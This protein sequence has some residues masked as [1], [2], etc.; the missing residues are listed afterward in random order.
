MTA[1]SSLVHDRKQ[2][3]AMK[4]LAISVFCAGCALVPAACGGSSSTAAAP[5]ATEPSATTVPVPT[6][7]ASDPRT[8]E[9]ALR[10]AGKL[11]EE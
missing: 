7:V 4:H 10:M 9:R 3:A 11:E 8:K 5:T 1:P 2:V 6:T